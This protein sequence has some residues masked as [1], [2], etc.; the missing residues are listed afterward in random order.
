[1]INSAEGDYS[2]VTGDT[3]ITTRGTY[4]MVSGGYNRGALG[5]YDW[6]GGGLFQTQ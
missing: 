3:D 2:S 1:M 5:E 4:A 6:A